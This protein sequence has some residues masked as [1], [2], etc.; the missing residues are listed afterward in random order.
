[1]HCDHR[2]RDRL[3]GMNHTELGQACEGPET[4]SANTAAASPLTDVVP[5]IGRPDRARPASVAAQLTTGTDP[6][7][8]DEES[9]W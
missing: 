9:G 3:P 6:E 4:S 1:M 5:P 2:S 8:A 7:H